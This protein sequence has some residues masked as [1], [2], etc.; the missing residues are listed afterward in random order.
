[1]DVLKE[2][3][4]LV[5]PIK[6]HSICLPGQG[7]SQVDQFYKAL[8][9]GKFTNDQ[10][11]AD[12]FFPNDPHQAKYYWHLKENLLNRLT[13]ASFVIP[14]DQDSSPAQK[15]YIDCYNE[16]ALI[17]KFRRGHG[18]RKM[19]IPMAEKTLKRALKY[20]ITELVLAV[21]KILQ[22]HYGT[23]EGNKGKYQRYTH[24]VREHSDLL[25]AEEEAQHCYTELTLH[26]STS[27]AISPKLLEQVD[28]FAQ[29]LTPFLDQFKAYRLHLLIYNI[30]VTRWQ[31]RADPIRIIATCQKALSFFEKLP[32]KAV[33]ASFS[34]LYKMIPAYIQLEHYKEAQETIQKCVDNI[35]VGSHNW[36][37]TMQ[38]QLILDFYCGEYGNA[39]QTLIKT[40]RYQ[41]KMYDNILEQWRINQAYVAFFRETGK[42]EKAPARRFR[43]NKFLNEVPIYEAD[44]RGNNITILII[45][46]MFLLHRRQYNAV[47]DRVEALQQYC[48]RYLRKDETFRSNCFIKMILELPKASFHRNAVL[49]KTENYHQRLKEFPLAISRQSA[50]VELVPYEKLWD[51]VLEMLEMKIVR[52]RS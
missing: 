50:E 22:L 26:F 14:I 17:E 8:R 11:A 2:L 49:R 10:E 4:N 13:N 40:M 19:Y 29:R 34:F 30:L 23:I 46:L 31:L 48:Y 21:S 1:M 5:S 16:Y 52:V 37:V 45:Q 41:N 24:M 43:V 42:I 25:R 6:L 27:R 35:K 44:K 18:D 9:E 7:E 20:D 15:A 3:A 33:P 36:I 32:Y 28:E 38:Y 12:Y 39:E 51:L 47:I